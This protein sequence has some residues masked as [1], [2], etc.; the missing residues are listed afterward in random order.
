MDV[1]SKE[2]LTLFLQC[3]F[4]YAEGW[5]NPYLHIVLTGRGAGKHHRARLSRQAVSDR[6]SC[7]AHHEDE[8]DPQSQPPGV[9][10]LQ[11][12]QVPRKGEQS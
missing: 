5:F 10:A 12:A 4:F 1:S 9:R 8:E 3:M 2:S 6:C 7:G 11:P